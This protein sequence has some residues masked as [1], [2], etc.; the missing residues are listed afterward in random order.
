MVWYYVIAVLVSIPLAALSVLFTM[1]FNPPTMLFMAIA[2]PAVRAL[3]R[4]PPGGWSS[5]S[6]AMWIGAIW[7]LTLAPLH[8]INYFVLK[9]NAWG[10]C[11]LFLG[12]G[13][14]TAWIVMLYFS[15][16]L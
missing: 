15:S 4:M 16:A 2:A 13:I 1:A 11:G 12:V 7:P 5:L 6:P 8:W 14:L 10:Y 9:G 3:G